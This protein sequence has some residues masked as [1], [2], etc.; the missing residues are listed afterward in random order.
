MGKRILRLRDA[1]E[2]QYVRLAPFILMALV[3]LYYIETIIAL[4]CGYFE[5]LYTHDGELAYWG[6]IKPTFDWL[7]T[8]FSY[9][10]FILISLFINSRR[11]LFCFYHKLALWYLVANILFV[12]YHASTLTTDNTMQFASIG[13]IILAVAVILIVISYLKYGDRKI[14]RTKNTK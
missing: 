7:W 5:D 4:K 12:K 8:D 11:L 2:V 9:G 3:G 14:K 6:W 13:M 1:L 10:I